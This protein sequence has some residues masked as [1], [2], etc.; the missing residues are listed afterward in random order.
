VFLERET[1]REKQYER[2]R[3]LTQE[4]SGVGKRWTENGGGT[5]EMNFCIHGPKKK[6]EQSVKH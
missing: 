1:E 5:E 4:G 2:S 3:G 6:V